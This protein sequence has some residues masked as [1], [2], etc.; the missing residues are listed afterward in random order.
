MDLSDG[1]DSGTKG[2]DGT[3]IYRVLRL[4]RRAC[5]YFYSE[6]ETDHDQS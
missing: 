5:S 6:K 1:S 3:L 4:K 2:M